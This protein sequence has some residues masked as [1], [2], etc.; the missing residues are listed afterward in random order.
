MLATCLH[1]MQGTPYVYQ[2]EEIGMTNVAFDSIGDYRDIES[3]NGYRELVDHQGFAPEVALQKVRFRSR[4]NARTPM[5][6]DA[7]PGAGFTRGTP[8]LKINPNHD[9]INVA[10]E[11]A[12]PRSVLNYYKRL[13][14]L[15][16]QHPVMIYGRYD[17]VE[18]TDPSVYAFTR[19]DHGTKLLVVCSFSP[20]PREFILPDSV[21]FEGHRVL[22]GNYPVDEDESPLHCKLKPF[23]ARVYLRQAGA[24]P[25]ELRVLAMTQEASGDQRA[26]EAGDEV[27]AGAEVRREAVTSGA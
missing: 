26:S 20:E 14:A 23:E 8:W 3:I 24:T 15:R 7:S 1:M 2:G 6:W 16:K 27:E 10:A 13:I 19:E 17:L 21:P 5:Q 9:T 18:D 4:D 12:D 25:H 22:L 11:S